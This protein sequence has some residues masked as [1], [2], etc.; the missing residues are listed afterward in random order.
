RNSHALLIVGLDDCTRQRM[1]RLVAKHQLQ[2]SVRLHGFA[3]EADLPALMS[4]SQML[5]FPSL[6]EG[7][8]LPVLDAW[9][10][11][12]PVLTS[13][14]TSLPEV[15]QDAAVLVDP[16]NTTAIASGMNAL[17]ND[18]ARREALVALGKARL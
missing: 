5:A 7:F 6:A 12:T 16:A 4:G 18:A 13:S 10:T 17:L 11:H 1:S 3:D 8:G 14:T 2:E 9:A 15:A